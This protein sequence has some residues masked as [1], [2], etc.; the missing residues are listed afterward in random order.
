MLL[1]ST[2]PARPDGAIRPPSSNTRLRDAPRPR[3]STND[4]PP[5]PLFTAEPM[6]G[7]MPGISRS[8][9]SA[10]LFW[11]RAIV[12]AVVTLTG[13]DWIK[14]GFLISEPVT[15]ISSLASS[16]AASAAGVAVC[17]KA[18]AENN[19]RLRTAEATLVLNRARLCELEVF[20][21]IQ[22][23]FWS[24]RRWN[25]PNIL[26]K[27]TGRHDSTHHPYQPTCAA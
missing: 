23:L 16:D 10:T 18:G 21:M 12:S 27:Q 9:S 24:V 11:R 8:T 19:A 4:A 1:R 3:R 25:R 17:A 15:I 5:L 20:M 26:V 6:F 14:L 2:R 7:T 13:V 22:S